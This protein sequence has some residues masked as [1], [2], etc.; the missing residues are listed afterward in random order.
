MVDDIWASPQTRRIPQPTILLPYVLIMDC[1]YLPQNLVELLVKNEVRSNCSLRIKA[2]LLGTILVPFFWL[3]WLLFGFDQVLFDVNGLH[4]DRV[5]PRIHLLSPELILIVVDVALRV[6]RGFHLARLTG[7]EVLL[8]CV[9]T[10]ILCT[11]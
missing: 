9:W 3:Y 10:I 2:F 5:A 1:M 4:L 7:I 6:G 11:C 8:L